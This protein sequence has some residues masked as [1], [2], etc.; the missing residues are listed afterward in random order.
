MKKFLGLVFAMFLFWGMAGSVGATIL[1]FDDAIIGATSYSFDSDG[2]FI[3][4]VIFTT[5]DPFGFNTV[6]PGSNMVLWL[7]PWS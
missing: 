3:D 7:F 6:G 1:T 4:D 2:D 5:T